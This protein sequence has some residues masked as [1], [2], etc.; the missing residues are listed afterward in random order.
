MRS[1]SITNCIQSQTGIRWS[2]VGG[3]LAIGVTALLFSVKLLL[4]VYA[5][6][7]DLDPSF[8][9]GG[10]VEDVPGEDTSAL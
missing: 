8:G 9:V 5:A 4:A 6:A 7:G 10:R 2:R 3:L 1:L